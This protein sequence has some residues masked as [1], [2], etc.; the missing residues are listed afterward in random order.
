MYQT[1][2]EAERSARE[3][4]AGEKADV[5]D[6]LLRLKA[7]T[8]HKKQKVSFGPLHSW[9]KG[10]LNSFYKFSISKI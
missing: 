10:C 3:K 2:F 7:A 5:A 8:G 4:I 9:V 6:E 1:D